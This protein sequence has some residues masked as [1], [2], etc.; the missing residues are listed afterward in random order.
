MPDERGHAFRECPYC[1]ANY[2]PMLPIDHILSRSHQDNV[3]RVKR[4][5]KYRTRQGELPFP[6][7][8]TDPPKLR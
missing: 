3:R 5:A 4:S 1:G 8:P 7:S 6:P 2:A